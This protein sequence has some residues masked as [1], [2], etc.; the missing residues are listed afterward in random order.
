MIRVVQELCHHGIKG[1]KWGV[2]RYQN[3]DGTLTEAGKER[4]RTFEGDDRAFE[5]A[6]SKKAISAYNSTADIMNAEVLPAINAKYDKY[7]TVGKDYCREVM[8]AYKDVYTDVL[9]R[10]VGLHREL[11]KEWVKGAFMYDAYDS[12][13][14]TYEDEYSH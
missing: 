3:E 13:V 6:Y 4:Y 9:L 8:Q 10:E 12:Y 14:D 5:K 7:T 11:G 2:R 1:M